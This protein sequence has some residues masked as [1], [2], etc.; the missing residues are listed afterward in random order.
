MTV[1][2]KRPSRVVIVGT[3]GVGKSTLAREVS[4]RIDA[5][6]VELDALHWGPG[7]TESTQDVLRAR[8]RDALSAERWVV[9][10]NYLYLRDL[11]WPLADSIVWLDYERSVVMRRVIW[12]TLRRSLRR[13]VL[14]SGNRE[15]IVRALGR[16]SIV[17]WAWD[18][19]DERR[20]TYAQL[21]GEERPSHLAVEHHGTPR[22]TARWVESLSRRT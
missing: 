18:T 5:A 3:S 2:A 20:A 1:S 9:D 14:W 21:L 6:Y 7:W 12:R 16:D 19:F 13:E 15:S 4:R 10:G 22:E 11:V 8:V 17:K